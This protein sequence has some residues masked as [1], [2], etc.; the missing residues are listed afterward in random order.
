MARGTGA[1]GE[2][3]GREG[4][5]QHWWEQTAS[6]VGAEANKLTILIMNK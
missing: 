1:G 6:P 3:G 4:C 2:G 5:G